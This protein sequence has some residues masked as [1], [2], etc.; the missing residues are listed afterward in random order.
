MSIY[1]GSINVSRFSVLGA[2]ATQ[3]LSDLNKGMLP[4]QAEPIKLSGVSV[5][6]LCRWV[7]PPLIDL[8]E[9][10]Q[11]DMADAQVDDGFLLR[12]RVEKRRVAGSLLQAIYRQ[13]LIS[14]EE[15]G[16]LSRPAK[17]Q[18]RDKIKR[19]LLQKALPQLS[20]IDGFWRDGRQELLVFSTSNGQIELFLKHFYEC[21][22][23]G[24]DLKILPLAPPLLSGT[25]QKTVERVAHLV[26]TSLNQQAGL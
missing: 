8:P 16:A 12:L 26:P 10:G 11:W 21:F 18:L 5:E 14:E 2:V 19:D 6:Q 17:K 20:Y 22:C 25:A 15:K 9:D 7:R 3:R 24:K 23:K 4:M 13:K 1:S